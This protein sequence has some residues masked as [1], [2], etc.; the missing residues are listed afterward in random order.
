LGCTSCRRATST[1][2]AEG[3]WLSSTIRSFSIV[4][5]RRRRSGPDRT[6]TLLTFAHLLANQSANYRRQ[7]CRP[8][9]GPHRRVTPIEGDWPYLWIDATYV[10]VRQNGRIVSV[11]VIFAVGV[12]SDVASLIPAFRQASASAYHPPPVAK[13]KRSAP[14]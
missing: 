7:S 9:G 8:E 6:E 10:K 13:R 14:P 11:A 3:A 5:H 4:V 2:L 12:N 1:T